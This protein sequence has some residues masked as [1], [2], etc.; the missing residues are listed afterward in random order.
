[1]SQQISFKET[2]RKVFRATYNDGL[3]KVLPRCKEVN[4]V[5]AGKS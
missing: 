4:Y 1:M 5:T 2:E 3:C